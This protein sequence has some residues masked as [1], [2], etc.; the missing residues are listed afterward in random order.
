LILATQIVVDGKPTAWC[1]SMTRRRSSPPRPIYELASISG[2]E[3]VGI[4]KYL[5]SLDN[6]SPEVRRAIDSA[7]DWFGQVKIEGQRVRMETRS[8]NEAQN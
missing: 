3:S 4:V 2:Y 8:Q 7:V 1:A 5:M 6:P